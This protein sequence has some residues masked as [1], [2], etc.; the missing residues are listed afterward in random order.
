MKCIL[1][2]NIELVRNYKLKE[3]EWIKPI[4]KYLDNNKIDNVT[5]DKKILGGCSKRKPDFFIDRLTH[6]ITGE[7]D[8]NQH[9]DYSCEN[10]RSMELFQ[11]LGNRPLVMLRFNPDVSYSKKLGCLKVNKKEFNERM[12]IY[13]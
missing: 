1:N 6:C 3:Q 13:I 9:T 8:E 7:C 10:R 2:P 4:K 12:N 5:F 11:D